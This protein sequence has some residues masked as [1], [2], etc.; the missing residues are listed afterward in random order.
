MKC[1]G[2]DQESPA[3]IQVRLNTGRTKHYCHRCTEE[4]E[5]MGWGKRAGR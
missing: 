4:I 1:A 5:A 3:L 2:C